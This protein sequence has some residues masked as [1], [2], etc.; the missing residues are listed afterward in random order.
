MLN[1]HLP[2]GAADVDGG[3]RSILIS[4]FVLDGGGPLL[5]HLAVSVVPS[6]FVLVKS[7]DPPSVS[8]DN[9]TEPSAMTISTESPYCSGKGLITATRSLSFSLP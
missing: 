9:H 2:S 5:T 4:E 3:E 7:Y 1:V 6:S 8:L